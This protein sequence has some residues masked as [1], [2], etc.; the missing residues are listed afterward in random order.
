MPDHLR[1]VFLV[2]SVP[3]RQ[4]AVDLLVYAIRK[5]CFEIRIAVTFGFIRPLDDRRTGTALSSLHGVFSI[6]WVSVRIWKVNKE[7]S[8][9]VVRSSLVKQSF[10]S[11]HS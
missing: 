6:R 10:S 8:Y 2:V 7:R 1:M 4:L 11:P 9:S 3:R 5:N